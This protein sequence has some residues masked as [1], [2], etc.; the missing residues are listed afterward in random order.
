MP[1]ETKR[2][3]KFE[4]T[5]HRKRCQDNSPLARVLVDQ[6]G[7]YSNKDGEM[8]LSLCPP[9]RSMLLWRKL[10]RLVLANLNVIGAIPPKLLSLT[11]IGEL[12]I[13]QFRAK[14]CI[15]KL[16]GYN[17]NIDLAGLHVAG[18]VIHV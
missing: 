6:A 12:I 15:V 16:Q 18:H 14:L 4:I 10:P 11:L 13:S 7:V 9:C 8:H 1:P 2:E 3:Q 5:G 17:N